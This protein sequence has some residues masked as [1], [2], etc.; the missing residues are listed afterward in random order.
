MKKNFKKLLPFIVLVGA[1]ASC[2][3][4]SNGDRPNNPG[5]G[6]DDD[7]SIV[8][9]TDPNYEPYAGGNGTELQATVTF[10]HTMGSNIQ[11]TFLEP[12]IQ[13]FEQLYP[14]IKI[15]HAAQGGYNDIKSK[16][17]SAIPADTAPSMAICYP[18]HVAGYLNV[19]HGAIKMDGYMTDPKIGFGK[20]P[21]ANGTVVETTPA[22]D[23]YNALEDIIPSFLKEGSQFVGETGYYCL[24]LYKSSEALFYN[25][26]EF[27]AHNYSVPKTWEE[28]ITLARKMVVDYPDRFGKTSTNYSDG[29]FYAA[30]IGYDSED[31]MFI[32]FAK[33]MGIPYTTNEKCNE[34]VFNTK[35]AK[36]MVKMIKGW[37]DEGL[38]VCKG[39]LPN[40]SYTSTI[41]TEESC[42]MSIGSTGGV[43]Y[44]VTTNFETGVAELPGM[45]GNRN[46]ISQGPSVCFFDKSKEEETA[47]FL[48]Y[49]F[50]TDKVHSARSSAVTGYAPVR[51]SSLSTMVYQEIAAQGNVVV[52]EET[53]KAARTDILI[54][55]TYSVFEKY[56]KDGVLFTSAVFKGSAKTREVTG[57]IISS[58][59]LGTETIDDA[60]SKAIIDIIAEMGSEEC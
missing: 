25:V 31:N 24:P 51:T 58:V 1:L 16:I 47:S 52:S 14:G 23:N 59:C 56:V 33:M 38:I 30:P 18:D 44:N 15:E 29:K 4:K 21:G 35:E 53:S 41:F 6:D 3:S 39:T 17:D 55:K 13:E 19:S 26:D 43:Q 34:V 40:N 49:K 46:F 27:K 60:F 8:T 42:M 50:L 7:N 22:D 48:F 36:D 54:G 37:Y 5:G 45:N 11:T 32:S 9:P 2:G 10:W 12:T 20:A 28:M 57:E